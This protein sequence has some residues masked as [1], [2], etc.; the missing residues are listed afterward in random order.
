[1]SS[2]KKSHIWLI[3]SSVTILIIA[4]IL[5]V[6]LWYFML[7]MAPTILSM[8]IGVTEAGRP[9]G[10]TV[11]I[12]KL[13]EQLSVVVL[14]WGLIPIYIGGLGDLTPYY[15]GYCVIVALLLAWRAKKRW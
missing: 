6:L 9:A 11:E 1:M 15:V 5:F 8:F 3:I 2:S 10:G 12:L 14:R 4:F 13:Q 7:L